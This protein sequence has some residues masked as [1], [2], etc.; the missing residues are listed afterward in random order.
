VFQQA[1][2]EKLGHLFGRVGELVAD[3]Q[4]LTERLHENVLF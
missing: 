1:Q 4:E 3:Q 2:I